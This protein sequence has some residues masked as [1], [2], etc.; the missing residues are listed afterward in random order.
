MNCYI[1]I[2][3]DP[4]NLVIGCCD[5]ECLG[6]VLQDE[7]YHFVVNEAFYKD[8]LVPIEEAIKHLE[9]CHNFNVV[10]KNIIYELIKLGILSKDGT[11]S[12]NGIP[13]ALKMVL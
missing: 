10:G 2:H 6:K 9:K 13:I 12:I 5:E 7:E 3:G 4:Q 8:K 1:K 11:L